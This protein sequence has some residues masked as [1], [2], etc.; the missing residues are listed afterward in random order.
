M[1]HKEAEEMSMRRSWA[2][3]PLKQQKGW[4]QRNLEDEEQL[5]ILSEDE[6]EDVDEV[7]H[8]QSL[9]WEGWRIKN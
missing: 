6:E 3:E 4:K 2:K 7:R 8:D 9:W 5:R 1:F